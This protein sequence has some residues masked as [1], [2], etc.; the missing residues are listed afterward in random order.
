MNE[1]VFLYQ[2]RPTGVKCKTSPRKAGRIGR[3]VC[4]RV[5]RACGEY[6]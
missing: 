5:G 4:A 1:E 6:R 3:L 2:E